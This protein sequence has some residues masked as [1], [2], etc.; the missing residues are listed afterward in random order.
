[1]PGGGGTSSTLIEGIFSFSRCTATPVISTLKD[2]AQ[3]LFHLLA[4]LEE[5]AL[6]QA[7][8]LLRR[9]LERILLVFKVPDLARLD[10][11]RKDRRLLLE[12][13]ILRAKSCAL[14]LEIL[15]KL[16][17][18][19]ID[20]AHDVLPTLRGAQDER[21]VDHKDFGCGRP[22][23]LRTGGQR[24]QDRSCNKRSRDRERARNMGLGRHF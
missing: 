5:A 4:R 18:V 23:R 21:P 6:D 22:L 3:R 10:V 20:L 2:R 1:M 24:G 19:G 16:G 11:G 9:C 8:T 7:L 13:L 17:G 12:L 14:P 15:L